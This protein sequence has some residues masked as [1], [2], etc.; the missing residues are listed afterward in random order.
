MASKSQPLVKFESL[1]SL[2]HHLDQT[3]D[4]TL[5]I[6]RAHLLVEERLRDVLARV[7]RSP[8]DLSAVRLSF[9]QVLGVCR[10][11]VGRQDDP[12]WDFVARLNEVR[13]KMAHHLD[14]GDLEE[15]VGSVVEK[16]GRPRDRRP[17]TP[18]ARFREAAVFV[19]GYFDAIRGSVRLREGY[20]PEVQLRPP[21]RR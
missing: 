8:D 4:P 15:L 3:D 9:Y 2:H 7:C 10:A 6:L 11:I 1:D 17:A 20:G 12:A 13:N 5:L 19:C 18:V 14:P 16:L 21:R